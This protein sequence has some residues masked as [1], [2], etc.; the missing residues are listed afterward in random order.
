MCYA[1]K[2]SAEG[3]TASSLMVGLMIKHA[4]CSTVVKVHETSRAYIEPKTL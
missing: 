4:I 3:V 1:V 2:A